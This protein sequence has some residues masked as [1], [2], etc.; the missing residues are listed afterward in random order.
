[1]SNNIIS[2]EVLDAIKKRCVSL[3]ELRRITIDENAV[4]MD[5]M[6]SFTIWEILT[7]RTLIAEK[8]TELEHM[9]RHNLIRKV[10]YVLESAIV[11][12][13]FRLN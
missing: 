13:D 7:I 10:D 4:V 5:K 9:N 12:E 11:S 8:G 6:S 3:F 2:K 1:M